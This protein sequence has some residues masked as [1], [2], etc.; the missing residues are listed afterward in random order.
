M[1]IDRQGEIE[2]CLAY[3]VLQCPDPW[4]GGPSTAYLEAFLLGALIR[5]NSEDSTLPSWRI[6]GV[7]ED[8]AFYKQFVVATGNPTLSIKWAMALAMTHLSFAEGFAK[9][10]DESIAYHLANGVKDD[11]FSQTELPATRNPMGSKV[12]WNQL[13][14]RPGMFL[15]NSGWGLYCLLNGMQK[16][17][18]WLGLP[19]MPQLCDIFGG[20]TSKSER[21]YGSPFAAFRVY[22]ARGLLEWVG[23]PDTK[24]AS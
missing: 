2:R 6:S 8:P 11:R 7:L 23:L 16:G 10:R 1:T 19:P 17:G 22:D 4:I 5:R 15:A 9:L 24:S 14:T 3:T 20:I 21:S 12:F 13:A 18:D